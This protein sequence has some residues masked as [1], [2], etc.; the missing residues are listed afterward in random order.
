M[1]ASRGKTKSREVNTGAAASS[2][3][4][5]PVP[6]PAARIVDRGQEGPNALEGRR[7]F[8]I[9]YGRAYVHL[10]VLDYLLSPRISLG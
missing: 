8:R 10:I 4:P 6:S 3:L 5:P 2:I 1:D 9:T 7:S